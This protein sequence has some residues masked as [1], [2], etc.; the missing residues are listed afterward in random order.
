M[1]KLLTPLVLIFFSFFLYFFTFRGHAGNPTAQQ[2]EFE[3]NSSGQP[4]E[5]S[6][7]RSRWALIL[8]LINDHSFAIDKYASIGTPDIGK[9][10][11][12][13]Y[14]FFPPMAS[15]IAVPFYLIGSR[16]DIAQIAVFFMPMLFA[17]GTML[18]IYKY[19]TKLG[20]HWSVAL[21]SA[22]A[23]GF[24]TSAWGYSVTLFAHLISAFF[25]LLGLYIVSFTE[26]HSFLRAA[27]FWTVYA[28]AVY[29]DFP[30]VFIFLP[31]AIVMSLNLFDVKNEDKKIKV[32][33]RLK[34]F[35]APLIFAVFMG[36]YGYYNYVNFGNPTTL[37]NT[38]PRVQDLKVADKAVPE[39]D[40]NSGQ[41]LKTRNFTNGLYTFFLSP[42]RSLFVYTPSVLLFIFGIGYMAS[43]D[44][45]IE[46]L[47]LSMPA[48]CLT[49]YCM[50]GDPYG[51]WAFGSR[52]LVAIMPELI[53]MA[54]LGLQ[55]F[56]KNIWVK[57]LYTLVLIY[58]TGVALLAPITTNVIPP[59]VEAR[60][61]NLDYTYI[62]NW[63]MIMQ[64]NLSSF[65][66]NYIL[67]KSFPAFYYYLG[68]L[69]F[70]SILFT[71]L[72]WIPKKQV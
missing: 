51:G 31:L 35:F 61:L 56:A 53:I 71:I 37:S 66:Y 19:C 32:N 21:F 5:T 2:I 22:F 43:K 26:K 41:A 59:F 45:K 33:L 62:I 42:D 58:G 72:I 64:N 40:K 14:S 16:L 63:R 67:D 47:L 1:K 52:Y 39:T 70:T 36:L 60:Y 8:S 34:Y 25:L 20:L 6:Q 7:E 55:R 24:A 10:N 27:A 13:Y 49:L 4:F 44:K 65:F 69:A 3:Q 30:N 54:G 15:I 48:T 23:F 68:I 50:F 17:L 9:I 11:G 29:T 28:M 57:I 38:I 18:L 12:H 46:V